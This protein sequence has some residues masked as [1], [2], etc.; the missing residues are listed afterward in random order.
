MYNFWGHPGTNKWRH[1]K[2]LLDIAD[3]LDGHLSK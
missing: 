1:E 3:T 2:I